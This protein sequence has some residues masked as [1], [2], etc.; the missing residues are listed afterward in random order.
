MAIVSGCVY[1]LSPCKL[2]PNKNPWGCDVFLIPL[3]GRFA[4]AKGQ[5]FVRC[6]VSHLKR[7]APTGLHFTI[8]SRFPVQGTC[9]WSAS[10]R[11]NSHNCR[12]ALSS[13]VCACARQALIQGLGFRRLMFVTYIVTSPSNRATYKTSTALLTMN[14]PFFTFPPS[15]PLPHLTLLRHAS[16]GLRLR[17]GPEFL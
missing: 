12:L 4:L 1:H 17:P 6:G 8:I 16:R 2:L 13:C 14:V 3:A 10:K 15:V 11:S 9:R 5:T 7:H